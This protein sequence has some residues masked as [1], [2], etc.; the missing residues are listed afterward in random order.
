M[1]WD[2]VNLEHQNL[3]CEMIFYNHFLRKFSSCAVLTD[4][5]SSVINVL[6]RYVYDLTILHSIT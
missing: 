3:R 2:I 6:L 5:H 1:D 4:I